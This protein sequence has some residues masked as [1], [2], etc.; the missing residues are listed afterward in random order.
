MSLVHQNYT[1]YSICRSY[2]PLTE[3][4]SQSN[5]L[6]VVPKTIAEVAGE[7]VL[8]PL[9]HRVNGV[10]H[11]LSQLFSLPGAAAQSTSC[12]AQ[13]CQ[14]Q[15]TTFQTH[16]KTIEDMQEA[17]SLKTD[18]ELAKQKLGL[19]Q[20]ELRVKTAKDSSARAGYHSA[21]NAANNAK[22][23]AENKGMKGNDFQIAI[24]GSIE[25]N[26]MSIIGPDLL[27]N[28]PS[29]QQ[30]RSGKKKEEHFEKA[31]SSLV[32]EIFAEISANCKGCSKRSP[33][34]RKS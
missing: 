22:N 5:S 13:I 4:Y 10:F 8:A 20:E 27:R 7:R 17:F 28:V 18:V 24:E 1:H 9:L 21:E 15:L 25:I 29:L 14:T 12:E 23:R 26:S 19:L 6:E 11:S 31:I 34:K 32:T 3:S 16:L 30:A 2:P 33:I